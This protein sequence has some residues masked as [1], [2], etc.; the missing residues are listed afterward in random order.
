M[1]LRTSTGRVC[2]WWSIPRTASSLRFVF[3]DSLR[4]LVVE[5]LEAARAV[6]LAET[7]IQEYEGDTQRVSSQAVVDHIDTVLALVRRAVG[8]AHTYVKCYGD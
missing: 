4:A 5:R 7:V 6:G 2:I 8:E 1:D 3:L